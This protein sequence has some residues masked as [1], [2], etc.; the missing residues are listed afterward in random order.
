MKSQLIQAL[1]PAVSTSCPVTRSATEFE[2]K[3][4]HDWLRSQEERLP[5]NPVKGEI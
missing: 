5:V 3:L 2:T 1:E 4:D